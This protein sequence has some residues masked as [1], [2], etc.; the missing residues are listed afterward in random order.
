MIDFNG[1]SGLRRSGRARSSERKSLK[2]RNGYINTCVATAFS[3][4]GQL[5]DFAALS[6]VLNFF[7]KASESGLAN[8]SWLSRLPILTEDCDPHIRAALRVR[9]LRL[10]CLTNH[11]A[12]LWY[13][14]CMSQ[15][16]PTNGTAM[17][18]IGAFRKDAWTHQGPH[19]PND[20]A[21]LTPGAAPRPRP[22][23]RL[24]PPPRPR[25]NRRPSRQILN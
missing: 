21:Q 24:R 7:L 3:D 11:Y 16:P 6:T 12:D 9:A 5:L 20:W 2:I 8:L 19:L 15:H 25:G 23:H 14:A 1:V 18:V 10:C 22:P 13:D 4:A 17:T